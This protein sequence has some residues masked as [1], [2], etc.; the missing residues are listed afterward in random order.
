[1]SKNPKKYIEPSFVIY[2][3]R[4]LENL[5]VHLDLGVKLSNEAKR[6]L[7]NLIISFID[8]FTIYASTMMDQN[9]VRTLSPRDIQNAIRLF[10]VGE[11]AKHAILQATK[12]LT[13]FISFENKKNGVKTSDSEKAGIIFPPSRVRYVLENKLVEYKLDF[14][15]STKAPVYLATVI[16]YLISEILESSG[17]RA[18][19]LEKNTI[20]IEHIKYTID[21]DD[22]LRRT[23]CRMRF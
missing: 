5:E 21:N 8:H 22:E 6:Y 15:I 16:E 18:K 1:M 13:K 3:N 9:R 4:V 20:Q 17:Y 7:Q 12:A 2:I 19:D 11:L 10:F 14:R 23:L